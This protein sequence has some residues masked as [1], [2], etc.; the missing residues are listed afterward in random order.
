MRED[1]IVLL[2]KDEWNVKLKEIRQE[3]MRSRKAFARAI[4]MNHLSIARMENKKGGTMKT[5]FR[6][7]SQ[8]GLK[9]YI[10]PTK[11]MGLTE[12]VVT[13]NNYYKLIKSARK[14]RGI[15]QKELAEKAGIT[16]VSV[17]NLEYEGNPR[18]EA[19]INMVYAT[20]HTIILA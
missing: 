3:K 11:V 7:L 4:R 10:R 12:S 5:L 19:F 13:P 9:M 15:T 6:V 18:I 17:Q 16:S 1:Q 20:D 14:V 8:L 2:P